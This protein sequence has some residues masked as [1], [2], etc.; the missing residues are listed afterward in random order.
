MFIAVYGD[1]LCAMVSAAA[2]ASTGHQVTLH[3]S[4][5]GVANTLNTGNFSLREPGLADLMLEQ[6]REGRLQVVGL[7]QRPDPRVT[8]LWLALA[9]DLLDYAQELVG[10]LPVDIDPEFLVVNQSTFPVGSTEARRRAREARE[11]ADAREG[12]VVG[13]PDLRTG[14]AALNG[15][16]RSAQWLGGADIPWAGRLV[17]EFLR[18]AVP[19]RDAI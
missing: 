15:F 11:G 17:A 6:K 18:P 8:V 13:V 10:S 2:L 19:P 3:V 14:G 5:G 4:P 16:P 9:P 7:D 12:G 1:T